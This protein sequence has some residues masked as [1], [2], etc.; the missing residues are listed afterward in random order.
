VPGLDTVIRAEG[1]IVGDTE[2]PAAVGILGG[3]ME[4]VADIRAALSAEREVRLDAR[5]VLMPGLVDT[6]AHNPCAKACS[7]SPATLQ[8]FPSKPGNIYS[9]LPSSD[10][11]RLGLVGLKNPSLTALRRQVRRRDGT[12]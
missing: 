1:A 6:Q 5:H 12:R 9:A 10:G 4:D 8:S 3:R 7:Q 2:R 11:T